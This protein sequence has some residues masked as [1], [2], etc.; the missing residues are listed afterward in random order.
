MKGWLIVLLFTGQTTLIPFDYTP[1]DY[2]GSKSFTDD[3]IVLVAP[4]EQKNYTKR[5]QNII[6]L[7]KAIL[8]VMATI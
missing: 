8:N 2:D 4:T 5:S 3:E 6:G 7:K 1:K